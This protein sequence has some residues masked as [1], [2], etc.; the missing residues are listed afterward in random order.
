ML[1]GRV[2]ERLRQPVNKTKRQQDSFIL[3]PLD[4]FSMEDFLNDESLETSEAE[5]M[6]R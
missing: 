6:T 4:K 1:A 5:K 3:P 2:N